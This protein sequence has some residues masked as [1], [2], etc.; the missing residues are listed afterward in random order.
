MSG[1]A[2]KLN[3]QNS[4][5]LM[6]NCAHQMY[7]MFGFAE[8]LNIQNCINSTG[9]SV[10]YICKEFLDLQKNWISR[11]PKIQQEIVYLIYVRHVQIFGKIECPKQ[12]KFNGKLCTIYVRNV[13]IC[14]KIEC[15][16]LHQFYRKQWTLYLYKMF[17]FAKKLIVQN[18]V[19]LTENCV[20]KMYGMFGFAEKLK[21]QN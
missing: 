13:W 6:G 2:K 11:T 4:V 9:S 1:F 20:P 19:N 14:R 15:P 3:V 10:H 18:C 16:K 7:G 8:K 17:G 21:N 12:R 5:N